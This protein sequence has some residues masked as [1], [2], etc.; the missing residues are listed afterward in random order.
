MSHG[1]TANIIF[2]E[3]HCHDLHDF[4]DFV[5]FVIL[6]KDMLGTSSYKKKDQNTNVQM[7]S[8]DSE[9]IKK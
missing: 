5:I 8:N 9:M 4:R 3:T 1:W 2:Q 6:L 7:L